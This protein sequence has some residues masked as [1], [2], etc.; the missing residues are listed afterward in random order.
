MLE[1]MLGATE[2]VFDEDCLFLNV[3]SPADATPD[4]PLPVLHWIHGGA[5]LNGAGSGPWYDGSSLAA[6][7]FVVVTVNYR[8]GALGF[9][10]E[11]NWGTLDQICS[12][13]W[14]RD[15]IAAFGGD[16][17]NVTIFGESAGGSA[18]LSLMAAPAAEGLFHRVI[19]Q[20]PSI[21]QLRDLD[22]AATWE[23]HFLE[24]A[25]VSTRDEARL[26]PVDKILA[27]QGEV[28]AMPNSN[29]DMFTPAAG[30]LG[31]PSDIHGAVARNPVPLVIGTTRDESRLFVL[32]DPQFMNCEESKWHS[33]LGENF[34]DRAEHVRAVFEDHRENCNPAQLVA[35]VQTE[36]TF[37][38]PAI[39]LSE[40]RAD[41]GSPTWMYWF[42]WASTAFG[43]VI[44]SCH[45]LDIP[46]VF[47]NLAA[48]GIGMLLGDGPGQQEIA[49]RFADEVAEFAAKGHASWPGYSRESRSTLRID[50]TTEIVNDPEPKI[51]QLF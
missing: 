1:Q 17:G 50:H 15:N 29:Y 16:P 25:G 38:Q 51:R 49:T 14:V 44:G 32:F 20:S 35:A 46:F 8:L 4:E 23:A 36:H 2:M 48:P 6:R 47:D 28:I 12:L 37:R 40:A 9:L 7:G 45:A 3:F 34:G 21:R 42:T 27:A 19:A 41:L 43:G 33:F 10:G 30:G 26:L 22:S 31:L 5:Y 11:G 24:K 13:E 18:V 39:A